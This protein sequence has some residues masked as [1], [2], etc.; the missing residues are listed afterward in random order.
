VEES[1]QLTLLGQ[2]AQSTYSD[3]KEKEVKEL[4]EGTL[5]RISYVIGIYMALNTLFPT[6]SKQM[7]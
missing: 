1:Q 3:W 5:E 2:L 6:E 7:A 4:S